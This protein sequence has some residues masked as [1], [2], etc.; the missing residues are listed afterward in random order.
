MTEPTAGQEDQGEGVFTGQ[1]LHEL[2]AQTIADET[3]TKQARAWQYTPEVM[4]HMYIRMAAYVNEHYL[5]WQEA[6]KEAIREAVAAEREACARAICFY[7]EQGFP[8]VE[9]R[10]RYIHHPPGYHRNPICHAEGIL[11]R[12]QPELAVDQVGDKMEEVE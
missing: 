5:Q 9:K 8:V 1:K 10:G 6:Q 3:G 2:Y 11:K 12:N 7:C 4:R